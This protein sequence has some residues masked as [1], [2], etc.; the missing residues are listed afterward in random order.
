MQDKCVHHWQI[1]IANGPVSRGVCKL[2]KEVKDFENSVYIT[3]AGTTASF[4]YW[5][6]DIVGDK[7]NV[8]L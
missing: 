7:W 1:D 4:D 8:E 6:K 3:T 5:H 2:C